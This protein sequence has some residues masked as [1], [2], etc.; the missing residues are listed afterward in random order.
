LFNPFPGLRPFESDEEHLFF[1]R[2][3]ETDELL[4]RLRTTRLLAVVGTSGSG[5]SSLVRSGL[6]PSLQ[7]GFMAGAGSSW[8][9]ATH[10]PGEDPIGLLA[11][12]LESPDVLGTDDD[13]AA[14]RRVLIEATLRRGSK[15]L[16]EAVRLARLPAGHN[17]LVIVD[18]FEE[19]F[20][21][22]TS[23]QHDR[24]SD[25]AIA[26]VRL[27]LEATRQHD[28]PIFVVLTMRSDF[29]SECMHFPGLSEAVNTGLYL[30]GRMSRDAMRAAITGPV[31]VG[32]GTI[33]PRLVH[34]VLNDLGD[35]RDQLP[36]VQHALMRTW[37]WWASHREG[38]RPI[39]LEDYE[40]VGTVR[41]AL[42]RHAEEAFAEAVATGGGAI[43]ARVFK[44]LTDTFSDA[45]GIRRPSAIA[46]LAAICTVPEANV[47][48]VVEIFRRTGRSFLMPPPDVPLTP[49]S[50]VDISHESLMRCWRR[51]IAW[52]EEER[53]AAAFYVRM[54]QAAAWH[55]A[56]EAGLWQNPELA[57]AQRWRE[58]TRPTTA[59]AH[60]Y[61]PRV[62]QTLAFLDASQ[63]AHDDAEAARRAERRARL[64]RAQGAAAILA[65]LFLVAVVQA[66]RA[67][68]ANA[69]AE[70]NLELARAAVDESLS[71]AERDPA[72]IGADV[73]ALEE[74]R[75]ELLEKAE[76]FYTAFL[77]QQPH[78]DASRR[79]LAFAHLRVGHIDR[80]LQRREAAATRY[81]EAI[82][83]FTEISERAPGNASY[84]QA[85][86]SAYNWLGETLRPVHAA[87]E[88]AGQAYEGALRIQRALVAEHGGE[89]AYQ[90]ELARTLYNRGIFRAMQIEQPDAAEAD[91]REAISWLEPLEATS[92]GAAQELARAHNN[93]AGLLL[94]TDPAQ[95]DAHYARAIA[96]DER[97]VAT[98]PDNR[99]YML[100]LATFHNNQAALAHDRGDTARA[101]G[102]SQRALDLLATLS[103]L[104]PSLAV[105]QADAYSLRGSI[106][107]ESD[108]EAAARAYGTAVDLFTNLRDDRTVHA[109]PAFHLRFGDL[110]LSLAHSTAAGGELA[111]AT[112]LYADVAGA[113]EAA[114]TP[115]QR[116]AVRETLTRVLP[117]MP[118]SDQRRL[119]ELHAR[120]QLLEKDMAHP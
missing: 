37:D 5:K 89:P 44:A 21:F 97:L 112:A 91:F 120:L 87:A 86:G 45:R 108:P 81:R 73:P 17:V 103:R 95:A 106:L 99:E 76:E 71:A 102:H 2:E 10:R 60:R 116:R 4:R 92:P 55:E 94:M 96:I 72:A 68:V 65:V 115:V 41:D 82:A 39:D 7:S 56:G 67:S 50:I 59:W 31:A 24:S 42:S 14:T 77:V 90:R 75:R 49:R 16:A 93:L 35:D 51:L 107:E 110:L 119:S 113:I 74:F 30:V 32:G 101:D 1:G 15:G 58:E 69:R 13:L 80:L 36:L 66:W 9:I 3:A 114:G 28:L 63:Q 84:R 88:E 117:Y 100:E 48:G 52:A 26:F 29:I 11:G 34:R 23:R 61:D 85:L 98:H 83:R 78:T 109:L 79:D 6:V 47:I 8:R 53:T 20:R 38:D 22:R 111:R 62:G 43:A 12:A 33:A 19:L 18:Q 70:A 64:R 57:L 25:D 40:A 46:E 105:E 54:A 27:L 104:A 118:A